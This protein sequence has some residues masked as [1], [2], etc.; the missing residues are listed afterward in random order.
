[1]AESD[2]VAAA[3]SRPLTV[4]ASVA[5][6]VVAGALTV[7]HPGNL[8]R[9]VAMVAAFLVLAATCVFL[10]R[11]S[12]EMRGPFTAQKHII[13]VLLSWASALLSSFAQW[14]TN[15]YLRDD[16]GPY[17]VAITLI[18]TSPYRPLR[19]LIAALGMSAVFVAGLAMLQSSAMTTALPGSAFALLAAAPVVLLATAGIAYARVEVRTHAAENPE[20]PAADAEVLPLE[21]TKQ[22]KR[23]ML[24]TGEV[25]PLFSWVVQRGTVTDDDVER[26][27]AISVAVRATMVH[28]ANQS[29][30][31][32]AT[33][34]AVEKA[35]SAS[36]RPS[37]AA[38]RSVAQ[39][40][41]S[42]RVWDA[43]DLSARMSFEQRTAVRAMLEVIFQHDQ[44]R[45]DSF[46]VRVLRHG[47]DVQLW[48]D[49]SFGPGERG[50]MR[51]ARPPRPWQ[52][53]KPMGPFVAVA[54]ASFSS[55]DFTTYST[56]ESVKVTLRFSYGL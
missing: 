30:V 1:M 21:L 39:I 22:E 50:G 37:H 47:R 4:I 46:A 49:V 33:A 34:E 26:A 18:A 7:A 9:P 23:V 25:A 10:I 54:R 36:A 32:S 19:S 17:V 29:W 41:V 56:R 45:P 20:R 35:Q 55:V 12:N 52:L 27:A 53:R 42:T 28:G 11:G 43:S 13:V 6:L 48:I 14:P 2:P 51:L 24:L 44:V 38:A 3:A 16:W 40:L 31:A 8:E 15:E 5:A